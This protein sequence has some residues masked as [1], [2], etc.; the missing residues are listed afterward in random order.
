M[1]YCNVYSLASGWWMRPHTTKATRSTP[2]AQEIMMHT[3]AH[4]AVWEALIG[5]GRPRATTRWSPQLRDWG[6]AQKAAR[7]QARLDALHRRWD[8]TWEAVTPHRA[9]AAPEMAA[10]H[11]ALSVATMLSGLSQ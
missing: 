8:A 4:P 3:N 6:T 1:G 5:I 2:A 11:Q 10:A 9:E 7:Q